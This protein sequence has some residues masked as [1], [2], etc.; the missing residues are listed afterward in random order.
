[1]P[2]PSRLKEILGQFRS[3]PPKKR[4]LIFGHTNIDHIFTV[5]FLPL[6]NQTTEVFEHR[7]FF[8]GTGANIALHAAVLGATTYLSS[9][10]GEDFPPDF[11]GRLQET[12]INLEYF[13][14]KKE[15]ST[16]SCWIYNDADQN[17][18]LFM[19]QGAMKGL[20]NYPVPDILFKEFDI[21]HI[22]TGRPGY[23]IALLEKQEGCR[24]ME[25]RIPADELLKK[26]PLITFD[27]G[28]ELHYVYDKTNFTRIMRNVDVFF[29]NKAE[30]DVAQEFLG[31]S[32]P[33][34]MNNV[35][36][37]GIRTCGR[38]GAELYTNG[39]ITV[40]PATN[41]QETEDTTGAGDAFRGGLYAALARG[42]SFRDAALMGSLT[43]SFSL[44]TAGGQ[45]NLPSF[46]KLEKFVKG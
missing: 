25:C 40:I 26:K 9:Y 8:G 12:G 28:Q 7:V 6:K 31:L 19:D 42:S 44:V 15:H 10:V 38:E 3:T 4:L 45:E 5:K 16:P 24:R 20:D 1:M 34:E 17:Q 29:G 36:P 33:M 32:D 41:V 21:V 35:V 43:A 30:W 22:G 2:S 27:P 18:M 13:F 23:Y 37:L 39:T 11:L 14:T 46:E